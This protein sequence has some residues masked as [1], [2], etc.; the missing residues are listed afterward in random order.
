MNWIQNHQIGLIFVNVNFWVLTFVYWYVYFNSLDIIENVAINPFKFMDLL[1]HLLAFSFN[2]F[3]INFEFLTLLKKNNQWIQ[4]TIESNSHIY[5]I[6]TINDWNDFLSKFSEIDLWVAGIERYWCWN[7]HIHKKNTID[8][9]SK[10]IIFHRII[11]IHV[12]IELM[13]IIPFVKS[14]RNEWKK[15]NK[16]KNIRTKM[17]W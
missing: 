3:K 8:L 11:S 2:N 16:R 10:A 6:Q 9:K 4:I 15:M 7:C 1:C 13:I 17:N 5:I 12:F 14:P